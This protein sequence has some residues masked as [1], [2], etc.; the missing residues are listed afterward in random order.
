MADG[1]CIRAAHESDDLI[2]LWRDVY[3]QQHVPLLPSGASVPFHPRGVAYTATIEN[4]VVGFC[5][6]EV[7][8]LTELWVSVAWQRRGIGRALLEHAEALMRTAGESSAL[9]TVLAV[10]TPAIAFY[11]AFGW[12]REPGELCSV[13]GQPFYRFSKSLRTP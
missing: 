12:Q 6:V 4:T 7:N 8:W 11:E 2:A 3:R 1:C 10:N 5:C 13:T 9:L